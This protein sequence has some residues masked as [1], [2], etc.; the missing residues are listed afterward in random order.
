MG[1]QLDGVTTAG[2][3]IAQRVLLYSVGVMQGVGKFS[4]ELGRMTHSS[5]PAP[6]SRF[7]CSLPECLSDRVIN[8]TRL[9]S[10][11]HWF[12]DP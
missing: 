6:G 12:G 1:S 7:T 2:D 5:F 10:A 11:P 4:K 9:V 8:H 3:D